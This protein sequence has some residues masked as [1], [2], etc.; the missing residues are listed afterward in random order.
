M[1]GHSRAT[2]R[3]FGGTLVALQIVMFAFV[4]VELVGVTAGE[5]RDA[6]RTLPR[7]INSIVVRILI[8]YVGAMAVI[9]SLVVWSDLPAD[10]S[11][12]AGRRRRPCR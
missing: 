9:M 1:L 5:A 2:P 11:P 7:A 8:F 3:G 12:A 10:Q 4:G 6:E